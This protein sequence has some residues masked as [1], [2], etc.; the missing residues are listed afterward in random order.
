MAKRLRVRMTW[1]GVTNGTGLSTMWFVGETQGEADAAADAAMDFWD[2]LKALWNSYGVVTLVPEV[3]ELDT[4]TGQPGK[5]YQVTPRSITGTGATEQLPIATQGLVRWRTGVFTNGR[6]LQGHTY[7]PGPM[8]G[9]NDVGGKPT[10]AYKTSVNSAASA[11][12]AAPGTSLAIWGKFATADV[13]TGTCW[14]KWA[15][16]RSRRD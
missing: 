16:L 4:G 14:E 11:L 12:I 9:S 7:I 3:T 8:E 10:A 6:E 15:I 13:L 1:A 2:A 5:M